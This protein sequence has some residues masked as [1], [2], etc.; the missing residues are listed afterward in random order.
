MSHKRLFVDEPLHAGHTLQ[1][2]ADIAH[3]LGRVLR[4]RPADEVLLFNGDGRQWHAGIRQL[5]R[6]SVTL[7]VGSEAAATPESP[8]HI[9]LWQALSRNEKMD[10]VIQKAVELGVAAIRPVIVERSV[11]QLDTR[12]ATRRQEHWRSVAINAA[13]Q[14]GRCVI[15]SVHVPLD[16]AAA[17]QTYD[18]SGSALLAAPDASSTLSECLKKNPG[19]QPALHLLIGPE[20]GFTPDESALAVQQGFSAF[21]AGPRVLRTE[22]AAI[23][24]LAIAQYVWGDVGGD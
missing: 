14:C 7:E 10:L 4:A 8:L 1:L 22:T 18:Q 6:R 24:L 23:A 21:R 2:G 16:L 20:G 11:M 3:Y 17:L 19:A 12:R 15:P 9:T 5:E 13:Q